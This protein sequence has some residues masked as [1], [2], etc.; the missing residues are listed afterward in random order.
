MLAQ[1]IGMED[2]GVG[3]SRGRVARERRTPRSGREELHGL[4]VIREALRARRRPLHCLRVGTRGL[5]SEVDALR[6]LAEGAGVPCIEDE[7]LVEEVGQARTAVLEAGP[8]P[9]LS[10]AELLASRPEKGWRLIALDGV[11]DPQNVG[12]IV[13]VAE[14]LGVH[15]LILTLRRAPPLSPAVSRASAGAVEWLPV[16]R[17][18]NL[19]RAL[20][21]LKDLG[22]WSFGADLGAPNALSDVP[23]H[24]LEGHRVLV[25]GAEGRGLREG[26]R[27]QIDFRIE[28]PTSGRISSLNVATAAAVLLYELGRRS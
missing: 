7:R 16:A 26:V 8:L 17:V 27:R 14:V 15:A 28:I 3:E 2:L 6:G 19:S 23:D 10:L 21:S 13:R 25:L 24:W 9:Q 12:A 11:E 5:G 20:E 22:V 4:H 1:V 18:P